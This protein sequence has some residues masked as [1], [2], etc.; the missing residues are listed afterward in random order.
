MKR[1]CRQTTSIPNF[2][3]QDLSY[4]SA[5]DTRQE[6]DMP[7][8]AYINCMAYQTAI[9]I[10]DL[11]TTASS[12]IWFKLAIKRK[13]SDRRWLPR[14]N[15]A[16]ICFY[17]S[18]AGRYRPVSYPDVPIT[19]RYRFIKNAYWESAPSAPRPPHYEN[20]PIQ[21]YWKFYHKKKHENF[22]IKI[23][24]FFIFLLKT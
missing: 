12:P 5:A 24:I 2:N 4:A 9:N 20:T 11:F 19:A 8:G 3:H 6:A 16:S 23:L 7:N 22:Q 14:N 18:I 21:I 15:P 10:S 17:K 13:T 1:S